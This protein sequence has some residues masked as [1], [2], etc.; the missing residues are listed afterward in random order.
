VLGTGRRYRDRLIERRR[1]LRHQLRQPGACAADS[2]T[3][4]SPNVAKARPFTAAWQPNECHFR[5][6]L[7]DARRL[8][9][10]PHGR[11]SHRQSLVLLFVALV[12]GDRGQL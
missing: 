3:I 9:P 7:A 10:A 1:S 5:F 12:G 4:D 11:A 8:E 2:T 6:Q